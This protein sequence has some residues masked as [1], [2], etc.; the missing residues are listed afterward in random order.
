LRC[1]PLP[2]VT[3]KKFYA[4]AALLRTQ[5]DTPINTRAMP[6]I[7][8]VEEPKGKIRKESTTAGLRDFAHLFIPRVSPRSWL[9][10]V[11][12]RKVSEFVMGTTS[13]ISAGRAAL[14]DGM[15]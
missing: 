2:R 13:D 15:N 6:T 3:V 12:K 8:S 9:V 1:Q 14:S 7:V 10:T 5:I 11:V 4:A